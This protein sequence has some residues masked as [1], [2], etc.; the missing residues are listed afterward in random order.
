M[1]E[2]TTSVSA[3]LRCADS[4]RLT[5]VQVAE[6]LNVPASTWLSYAAPGQAPAADGRFDARTPWWHSSTVG[7]WQAS[8]PRSRPGAARR[9]GHRTAS[10]RRL[11]RGRR[12]VHGLR[13]LHLV[14]LLR[15]RRLSR[16][17]V[18]G[19]PDRLQLLP[20]R[21]RE[22]FKIARGE[23][24]RGRACQAPPG[25][26]RDA[27]YSARISRRSSSVS[28]ACQVRCARLATPQ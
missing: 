19:L 4:T 2:P 22:P 16:A 28:A 25:P 17:G 8:R 7:Q 18:P 23:I 26:G 10:H 11:P 5:G 13:H 27:E 24:Q 1:P 12:A 14:W 21:R 15:L 6:C 9:A 20:M 3:S